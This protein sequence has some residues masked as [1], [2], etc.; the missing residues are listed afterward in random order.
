MTP[1]SALAM[2]VLIL[3]VLGFYWL[4]SILA[5]LWRHPDLVPIVLVNALL[6]W[7]IAGWVWAIARLVHQDSVHSLQLGSAATTAGGDQTGWRLTDARDGDLVTGI[8]SAVSAV[9]QEP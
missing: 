9:P 3:L 1:M 5:R 8:G 2:L 4:P 7:T 6:G